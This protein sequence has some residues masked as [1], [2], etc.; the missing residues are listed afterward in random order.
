MSQIKELTREMCGCI[1]CNIAASPLLL[2]CR[3]EAQRSKLLKFGEAV[4]EKAAGLSCSGCA[5]G[6][7]LVDYV[8]GNFHEF[9]GSHYECKSQAIRSLNVGE[10]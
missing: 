9:K 7:P 3:I 10:I 2:V 5:S 1:K 6:L 8:G 4:R